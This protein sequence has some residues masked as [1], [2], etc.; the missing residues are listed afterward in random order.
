M[1]FCDREDSG[2]EKEL[3]DWLSDC[4]QAYP[5]GVAITLERVQGDNVNEVTNKT[6]QLLI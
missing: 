4:C 1:V 5:D 2:V 3:A 6:D